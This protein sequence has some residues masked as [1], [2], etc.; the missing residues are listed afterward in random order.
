VNERA[1]SRQGLFFGGDTSLLFRFFDHDSLRHRTSIFSSQ[2]RSDPRAFTR[3]FSRTFWRRR[4]I[5]ISIR[6]NRGAHEERISS[7]E[8]GYSDNGGQRRKEMFRFGCGSTRER[9]IEEAGEVVSTGLDC[10][11]S[12][13]SEESG[14][15][16]TCKG[17][18][19][20][21]TG[22][23]VPVIVNSEQKS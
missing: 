10:E 23:K 15:E 12:R 22:D 19:R 2:I 16:V 11:Q 3:P 17:D 14:L 7:H 4:F 8:T 1:V 20:A 5:Y 18:P 9:R 21:E 6:P 13:K